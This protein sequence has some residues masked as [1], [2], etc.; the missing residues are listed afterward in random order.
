[1]KLHHPAIVLLID[2]L[3]LEMCGVGKVCGAGT[4]TYQSLFFVYNI[5]CQVAHKQDWGPAVERLLIQQCLRYYCLSM[6]FGIVWNGRELD[7]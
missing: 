5:D 7:L 2:H 3:L 1:M 6:N 4:Y